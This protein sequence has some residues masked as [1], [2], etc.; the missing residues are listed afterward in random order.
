MMTTID[1]AGRIV[2]PKPI[3]DQL[4]LTEGTALEIEIEDGELVIHR[5]HVA[6]RL[7]DTEHGV[8]FVADETMPPLS[9]ETVRA[10]LESIRR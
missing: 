8:V 7:V 10:A 4:G 3:R 5:P 1:K 9:I 2:V 6:K